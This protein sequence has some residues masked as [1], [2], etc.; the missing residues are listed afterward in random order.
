MAKED[1]CDKKKMDKRAVVFVDGLIDVPEKNETA[2]Q[3]ALAHT[4]RNLT[5]AG[6]RTCGVGQD[7]ACVGG[8]AM[9]DRP[10][11]A[12]GVLTG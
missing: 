10:A 7:M 8:T 4:V 5:A 11:G 3:Q 12:A 1:R 2:L 9:R 6:A